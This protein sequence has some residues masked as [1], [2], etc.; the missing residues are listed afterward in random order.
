MRHHYLSG[1]LHRS[2][3]CFVG[4][5]DG[6]PAVFGAV[7]T[8]PHPT[9]K[10]YQRE[11]RVVCLPDFQGVGIGNAFSAAL[12]SIC[13]ALGYR[14]ISITSHPAMIRARAK[15]PHWNMRTPPNCNTRMMA[16]WNMEKKHRER[17]SIEQGALA[18]RL[19]ATFEYVGPAID[20]ETARN[21]WNGV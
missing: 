18:N 19:R 7:L 11:H 17:T 1:E 16:G 12:G 5:V 21:L 8:F 4:Y 20:I 14:Y 15:S 2:S 9:V 6:T 3:R 10:N 13:R